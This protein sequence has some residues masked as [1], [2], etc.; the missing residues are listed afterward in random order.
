MK[1]SH[2]FNSEEML[3]KY[4]ND[5]TFSKL[6]DTTWPSTGELRWIRE[7]CMVGHGFCILFHVK[8]QL[9][10]IKKGIQKANICP[11]SMFF[12]H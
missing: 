11:K 9:F 8:C 12:F 3:L 4:T 6:Q 2:Y 7:D 5:S 1:G 10:L